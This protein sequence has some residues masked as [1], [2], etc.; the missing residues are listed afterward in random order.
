MIIKIISDF[1]V[2]CVTKGDFTFL[3]FASVGELFKKK[4][5]SDDFYFMCDGIAMVI[6]IALIKFRLVNRNSFDF[7][8]VANDVFEL[9]NEEKLKLA[10]VGGSKAEVDI[11]K[12]K[13][14]SKY[15]QIS[16]V[17]VSDG[18]FKENESLSV[19]ENIICLDADFV[20]VGLGAGKQETFMSCLR[21]H[22][23]RGTSFSCGGFISQ[24][25]MSEGLDYYPKLFNKLNLRF[26]YRMY[27]EPHTIKRYAFDYPK[28]LL[29]ML[30]LILVGKFKLRIL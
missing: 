20:I 26:L 9:C 23:F 27:R 28:N 3:N 8:S 22:G 15:S 18:Y 14:E 6:F 29:A 12:E 25:A 4:Y 1:N 30:Y 17:F 10:V 19:V 16:I 5:S 7:T 2:K 21:L 24:T 11:F 13:I